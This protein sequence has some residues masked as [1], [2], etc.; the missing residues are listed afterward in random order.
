VSG[1]EFFDANCTVG[2][3]RTWQAGEPCS[4]QD[5]LAEMDHFGIAEALVLDSLSREYHPLDG[6][7][8]VLEAAAASPRLHPA[9]A[10]LPPGVAEDQP[11]P[12]EFLRQ[13]RRHRV[14]A[15]FF[16][17][18]VYRLSL[19]DWCLDALLEPLAAARV[20]VF[21]VPN[22]IGS[23]GPD[24][25]DWEATVKLCRRWPALPVIVSEYRIRRSQRMAYRALE[26]CP[27]L[28]LELSGYWLY[29]GI[30]YLTRRFGAERLIFGS[31]WPAFG[32]GQT[33]AFLAA[34]EIS[35]ED[36]RKIAGGNLR[37]LLRWCEPA[38]PEVPERPPADEF[39]RFGRTG[40]RPAGMRFWDCHGH[41]G[42]RFSHYHIPGGSLEQTVAEM[43]RLGVEKACVFGF[44]GVTS[45]ERHGNDAVAEAVRRFPDRFV[46]FTTLNPH[47]GPDE[48]L[49]ELERGAKLG[50][51]G[52][53]LIPAYQGYPAEGPNLDV[54]CRWAHERRQIIL[55]HDWGSAAQMERF[56]TA[57]PNA[58][59]LTGHTTT[60]YAELM[61]RHANLYVCSCPLLAPRAC[62]KTVE[63]IGAGRLLFGSDLQDL[64]I[65]WGLGPI[66]FARLGEEDKRLVLGGN[67]ER[68]LSQYGL[69]P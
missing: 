33:L 68:I 39:V 24:Q 44:S 50:L 51:R 7:A 53:K 52:I 23:N 55:N 62:E 59:F 63:A 19:S 54:A 17:P 40:V 8:R 13:M 69:A 9:W 6:N 25:T 16:L 26:A 3:H 57:C 10:A 61:K 48:M 46:G 18:G 64:P 14:G 12:E 35:G 66:L 28:R 34:A 30:E 1:L 42:G 56:L 38:H 43:E 5:L 31:N 21:L 11:E 45:D 37:A 20:P 41:L 29:R 32:Q 47:R 15:V 36:K 67:L 65:A 60:A 49:R 4:A 22:D 27:N 58:C 2:R